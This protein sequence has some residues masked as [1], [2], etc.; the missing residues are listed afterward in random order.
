MT[1]L[2]LGS[3]YAPTTF[4]IVVLIGSC[5]LEFVGNIMRKR[6]YNWGRVA[7]VA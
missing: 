6:F 2:S 5:G 1:E 7:R 4:S 3:E